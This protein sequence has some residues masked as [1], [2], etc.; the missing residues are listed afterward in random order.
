L[1]EGVTL[2]GAM[3]IIIPDAL[4]GYPIDDIV[5]NNSN[6]MP[7]EIEVLAGYYSIIFDFRNHDNSEQYNCHIDDYSFSVNSNMTG[8]DFL[9]E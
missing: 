8:V 7:Y 5:W 6:S 2:E 9:L 1:P 3:Q 4:F